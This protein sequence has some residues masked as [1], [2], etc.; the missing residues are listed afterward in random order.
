MLLVPADASHFV[1]T[2]RY[3]SQAIVFFASFLQEAVGESFAFPSLDVLADYWLDKSSELLHILLCGAETDWLCPQTRCSRL[4]DRYLVR[5][6]ARRQMLECYLWS[7]VGKISVSP[8]RT[9]GCQRA[10]CLFCR[11]TG[12][13]DWKR[14]AF[15][16]RRPGSPRRGRRGD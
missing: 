4:L 5:I 12:S 7:S 8:I 13:T 6:S 14:L 2:E 1:E 11:S 10:D 3:A 9:H 16:Q 15:R